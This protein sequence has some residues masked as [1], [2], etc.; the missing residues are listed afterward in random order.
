MN[1]RISQMIVSFRLIS[2]FALAASG[3]SQ[4]APD[5][6]LDSIPDS[7]RFSAG[8]YERLLGSVRND[9]KI[10]RTFEKGALVTVGPKDWTSGFFP[11]SLWYLY[12]FTRDPKWL[13]AATDYTARLES[14]KD[15]QDSH[16][17]GFMLGCSYGNGYRLTKN[18]A[19]RDVILQGAAALA[20]RFHPKVGLLRSWDE[21]DW[22]YP[23]IIDNMMNLEF[24]MTATREGGGE[25]FREIS[26]KHADK[27]LKNHFRADSSSFHVVDYDPENGD[28]LARKT[29]QGAADDS[30]WAR[31]QGWA[32]YGYTMM[33][34]ETGDAVYL[35]Q[36][37]KVADFI[38][39]H[40]SL[41]ADKVPYWD[42][43][44]PGIPNTPRDASAAAVM[45]S[46]LIE[47]SGKVGGTKSREYLGLARQQ[48]ISLSSPAYRAAPGENGNFILMHSV[49]HLPARSEVDVP[50]NY[51]DYY[52]LEALL[53]YRQLVK[54]P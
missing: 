53:R 19:Y 10:P 6:L 4:A 45:S 27:T 34:R 25:R 16:D 51:A 50:L 22:K 12:E 32:L 2:V 7:F 5:A 43:D 11:G 37:V 39:N 23:V 9:P 52:Y 28:V 44:A 48:L 3:I 54:A 15:Y 17:V 35:T 41:P 46:A 26:I 31:G 21:G 47:L 8:Q 18:P 38:L 20:T 24:L 33:F 13:A 30:A 49:G 14:I 29:H 40:P 42:F 36:A 1:V